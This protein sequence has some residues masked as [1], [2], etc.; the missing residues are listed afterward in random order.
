MNKN[1]HEYEYEPIYVS[2]CVSVQPDKYDQTHKCEEE[3]TQIQSY[4]YEP[5]VQC[6]QVCVCPTRKV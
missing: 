6:E 1:K 3:N 4:E 2:R 5:A